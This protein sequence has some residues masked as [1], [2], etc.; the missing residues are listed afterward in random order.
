MDTQGLRT[1]GELQSIMSKGKNFI[2]QLKRL[3]KEK[4]ETTIELKISDNGHDLV[5][6]DA[7][8]SEIASS[9]ANGW[10]L[11]VFE[12]IKIDLSHP[13]RVRVK[14][15]FTLSGD[16]DEDKPSCG[17]AI[18]GEALAIIDKDGGVRFT[19]VT[20]ERD[21][22][23]DD[24]AYFAEDEIYQAPSDPII[25]S[26]ITSELKKYFA[27]HPEKLY[28]LSPR[29]FEIL[30]ADI[31]KDL[32]FTT[33]L[34][35]ATRDGGR[36]IYAYVKNAVTSFLMYVECKRWAANKKVGIQVVQRLHGAAKADGAHKSMIVTT[37]F[38]TIPAQR[39]QRKIS[40]QMEIKNYEALKEWLTRY[41]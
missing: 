6:A 12:V 13:D 30:I 4:L 20:A 26:D 24:E 3:S 28:E 10:G 40:A 16:Q 31:L 25:A 17:T 19:N 38:F 8:S 33:E 21:L 37:S 1:F 27:K 5:D 29:K 7:V 9:N 32:G 39:E 23:E 15:G 2:A 36:D 22:G 14:I 35:Q 11:D 34:T 41:K 18:N